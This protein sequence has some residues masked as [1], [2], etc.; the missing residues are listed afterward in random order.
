MANEVIIEEYA[1]YSG[2]IPVTSQFLTTQIKNIAATATFN[3]Q[4]RFI[5]IRAKGSGFW[6]SF[7]GNAAANTA[8]SS[9]LPIDQSVDHLV[10]VGTTFDTAADV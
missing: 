1:A 9:W 3:A 8:G 2:V 6:Y 7:N 10:S 5:R 4:T